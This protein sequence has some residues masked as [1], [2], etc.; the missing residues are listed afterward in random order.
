MVVD[1]DL[2]RS[3]IGRM[4]MII[5]VPW[6]RD[7]RSLLAGGFTTASAIASTSWFASAHRRQR[8]ES[9]RLRAKARQREEEQARQA[10][11][12]RE[13]INA[14][15]A[16]RR[17]IAHELHDGLGQDLLLIRNTALLA[18]QTPAHSAE[19]LTEIAERAARTIEEARSIA[20]SLRP[21]ELDRLG[22]LKAVQS[23]CED[24]AEAGHLHLEFMPE[25]LKIQ[26]TQ[27]AEIGLF[28]VVQEALTNVLKHA[29]ASRVRVDLRQ[30]ANTLCLRVADNGRGFETT[31]QPA[32]SLGLVGMRQ[33]VELL[34]GRFE[35]RSQ[36]GA[37]TEVLVTIPTGS[38]DGSAGS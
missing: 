32:R 26:L 31:S 10:A 25:P 8:R 9:E 16:E 27:E 3:K 33:R 13:L 11:F 6:S 23:L 21:Q 15:E 17:R 37:G 19:P 36:P 28:R 22:L 4:D 2:N 34:G 38:S 7:W 12:S 18:A 29:A 20:Y 5:A 30:A 24:V 14:Q 1:R 35:M